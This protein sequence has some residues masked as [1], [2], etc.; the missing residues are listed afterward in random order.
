MA[1]VAHVKPGGVDGDTWKLTAPLNPPVDATVIVNVALDP[2]R[3]SAG[4][5]RPAEIEKSGA[6]ATL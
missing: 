5:I 6:A 2:A 1:G 4:L 3:G